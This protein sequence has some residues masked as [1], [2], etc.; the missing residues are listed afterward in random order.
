MKRIGGRAI[1]AGTIVAILAMVAGFVAASIAVNTTSQNAQ[2]N[3]VSSTNAVTGLTYTSTVL[4]PVVSAP[5]GQGGGAQASP[6]VLASGA[7]TVCLVPTACTNG[8]VS[9]EITYTFTTSLAGSVE[10][11]VDVIGNTT[12]SGTVYFAQAGTP[13]AGTIVIV[14][15]LGTSNVIQSVTLTAQQCTGAGGACP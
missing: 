11:N 8:H 1:Y 10:F 3:F 6:P 9:D 4:T 12:I 2:G 7:N 14:A 5:A 13:V 15:D